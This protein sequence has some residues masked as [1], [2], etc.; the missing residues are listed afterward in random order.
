MQVKLLH[1]RFVRYRANKLY[2]GRTDGRTDVQ[3]ENITPSTA[4][5]QRR[6]ER[7]HGVR[8]I[9]PM[10]SVVFDNKIY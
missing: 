4:N 8:E 3:P 6:H 7:S 9:S 5:R 1:K 2:H 10:Q